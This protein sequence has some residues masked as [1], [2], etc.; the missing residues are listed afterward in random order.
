MLA[1]HKTIWDTL[2][3]TIWDPLVIYIYYP[4]LENTD[5]R[6]SQTG[7]WVER[8]IP[9]PKS[10]ILIRWNFLFKRCV[11][12]L[13][14]QSEIFAHQCFRAK[15]N[16]YICPKGPKWSQKGYPKW[17]CEE[18]TCTPKCGSCPN[19]IASFEYPSYPCLIEHLRPW[20]RLSTSQRSGDPHF[21]LIL[22]FLAL[23]W[24]LCGKLKFRWGALL[25]MPDLHSVRELTGKRGRF[26]KPIPPT[27][28][29]Y[30]G[31]TPGPLMARIMG[32]PKSTK[33]KKNNWKKKY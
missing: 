21:G 17:F 6:I 18:P 22:P 29:K 10:F 15:G 19:L 13:N 20:G 4:W 23:F 3:G 11:A 2:F 14:A 28:T 7:R 25:W 1:P 31:N 24:P 5:G 27:S 30:W 33:K 26:W 8:H 9:W 32:H 12:Q 16:K